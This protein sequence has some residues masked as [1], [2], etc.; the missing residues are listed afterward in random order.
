MRPQRDVNHSATAGLRPRPRRLGAILLTLLVTLIGSFTPALADTSA[1]E[2]AT[3][4]TAA[5]SFSTIVQR[6]TFTKPDERLAHNIPDLLVTIAGEKASCDFLTHYRATGGLTRWGYATSEVIEEW[7]GA[8][9][10]YYQRGVADCQPRE[11]VWRVE[12]RLVWDYL[13]GGLG[14]STDL[15]AEPD[16]LSEQP[17]LELGPWGHRVSNL[18]VDG[19]PT[20][21]LDFF[22]ALGGLQA[23][24]HPKSDARLDEDEGAMLGIE[25]ADLGV[26]RQYFQ[27]AVLEHQPGAPEPV[28][29]RFLGDAVRD[30]LYPFRVHRGIQSFRSAEPLS[31]DQTFVPERTEARYALVARYH[32]TRDALVALYQA[33]DGANWT[34]NRNWLSDAPIGEWFGVTA[35]DDGRV[36]ELILSQ[37]QLNGEIPAALGRLTDLEYMDLFG[38]QLQGEIPAELGSL[39]NLTVLR[40]WANQL[41]GSIPAELG[42]LASL[43]QLVLGINELS[44]EIPPELGNLTNL[45]HMDL[46]LNQLSGELPA[47]LGNLTNLTWLVFWSN[48]LQGD[49]P[50]E[51]GNLTN[52]T[53]LDLD[54]NRL[55]GAI[56][57]ELGNLVNLQQLYL[58]VNELSGEIPPELGTLTSLVLLGLSENRLTGEI[59]A[60]LGNLANLRTLRLAENELTGCIPGALEGVPDNDVSELGLPFC[61]TEAE[62]Q[63]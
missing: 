4:T 19:T 39:S 13:G 56:P 41:R 44:G 12:R 51:L 29:L 7:P 62:T 47:E 17:G 35:D 23:F 8:L 45:T 49:I 33:T 15:G 58:R 60:E 20:G 43:N 2:E 50:A 11:G 22:N 48:R 28:Q 5:D 54:H 26:I 10:Q 18:A 1:T 16:L 55:S 30:M 3:P 40:I 46:T 21:F 34:N 52:L 9:T 24:G 27:A 42:N 36:I 32:A 14:D 38:N 25:G 6:T 37:N 53:R 31:H 57:P 61:E 63:E 59:P